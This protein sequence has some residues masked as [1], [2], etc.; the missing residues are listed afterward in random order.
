MDSSNC[1]ALVPYSPTV[2]RPAYLSAV[3]K[4]RRRI[5][6]LLLPFLVA[7]SFVG[8]YY[9]L[10]YAS[11][12]VL[13]PYAELLLESCS[14][15][16][17]SLFLLFLILVLSFTVFSAAGGIIV[18]VPFAFSGGFCIS[19]AF[20][21]F[22]WDSLFF[23]T[24]AEQAAF[25]LAVLIFCAELCARLSV[26]RQGIKYVLAFRNTWPL[27]LKIIVFYSCFALNYF[28]LYNLGIT[29]GFL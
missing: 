10:F 17:S 26:T 21:D 5:Y 16:F 8:A 25:M 3:F 22:G 27:V 2:A 14:F 18:L 7:S 6:F 28:F 9:C 13:I 29:K 20:A 19:S 23:L 1:L 11:E 4:R 15:S 12:G 24:V